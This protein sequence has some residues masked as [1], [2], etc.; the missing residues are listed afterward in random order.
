MGFAPFMWP[1][2]LILLRGDP[3]PLGVGG[4]RCLVAR[5]S[6][7]VIRGAGFRACW[8]ECLF[9]A[10]K[11]HQKLLLPIARPVAFACAHFSGNR[12]AQKISGQKQLARDA[13]SDTFLP[14]SAIFFRATAT[15][16]VAR[17][18]KK[19]LTAV[20]APSAKP[21]DSTAAR[22]GRTQTRLLAQPARARGVVETGRFVFE[23]ASRAS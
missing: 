16:K 14:V 4:S 2:C 1:F 5:Y 10:A 11:R 9:D 3:R 21:N 15:Q 20:P 22:D 23:R 8:R 12:R 6:C 19:A 7:S 13:H 17:V 18:P